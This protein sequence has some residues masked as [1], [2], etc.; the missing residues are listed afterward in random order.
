MKKATFSAEN[1]LQN[2]PEHSTS[3]SLLI[4]DNLK[5][6]NWVAFMW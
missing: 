6:G 3:D 1:R 5:E 4:N 2:F